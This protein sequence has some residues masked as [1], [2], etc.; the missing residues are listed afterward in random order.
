[1]R[2]LAIIGSGRKHGNTYRAVQAMERRFAALDPAL[3]F[4][5]LYLAEQP[6]EPCLGCRACFDRG[7][8]CCPRKD[9]LAAIAE[10][11]LAADGVVFATP[12][13]VGSLSGLMKTLLD[14]LA[15]FCHRPAF[16]GKCA[17]V[18]STTASSTA[19]LTALTV[20]LPLSAM[21]FTVAGTAGVALGTADI[22]PVP[23]KADKRL[24]ALA[25]KMY[26]RMTGPGR[27]APTVPQ[28]TSFLMVRRHF[29]ANPD[30]TSYD[31]RYF[32]D[33]GWLAPKRRYYTDAKP[34][35]MQRALAR[36][37]AVLVRH[38]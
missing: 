8:A 9:G 25:Q 27:D 12:S 35:L 2:I 30:E 14:R 1:M 37:M 7:E 20:Q 10:K 19:R 28:L 26:R 32:R 22:V 18:V 36:A 5:Y 15:Y 33:R 21:G 29:A 16:H 38:T 4:E 24:Q 6:L 31:Y 3:T 23:A 34:T 13:Y 17:A 11:M